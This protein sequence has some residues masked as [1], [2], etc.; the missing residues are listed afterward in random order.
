MGCEE[1]LAEGVGGGPGCVVWV[2]GEAGASGNLV[3]GRVERGICARETYALG[4]LRP[5]VYG[6]MGRCQCILVVR[7]LLNLEICGKLCWVEF[8]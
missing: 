8:E 6:A 3:L 4:A 7:E 2:L 1:F 5:I